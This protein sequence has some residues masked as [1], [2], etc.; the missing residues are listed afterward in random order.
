MQRARLKARRSAS[1]Q[2]YVVS[3]DVDDSDAV[4]VFELWDD[5]DAHRAS[6]QLEAVQQ[7]IARA[8]PVIAAMGDR[9]KM[10]PVGGKGV[11]LS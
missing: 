1:C 7:L 9:F 11:A 8:R 10:Q 6:L 4:W 5:A 3:R 2:L